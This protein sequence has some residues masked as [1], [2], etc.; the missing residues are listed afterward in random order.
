MGRLIVANVKMM[1]RDRQ[2]LF[3]A[4]IFPLIFVV[5]F[6]LFDVG[7][8]DPVDISIIDLAQSP[9]SK[10]I[11]AQIS[12]IELLDISREFTT[13]EEA[14]KAVED[15]DLEYALIIP[16]EVAEI[17][18]SQGLS[19]PV[20]L[21]L[22]FNQANFQINQLIFGVIG[23]FTDQVNLGLAQAPQRISLSPQ[24]VQDKAVEYFDELVIGLV[25]MAIMFNSIVVIGV[26]ISGYRQ[27]RI[28]RRILVT[29]LPLRNYFAA[30]VLTHLALALVQ[31]S[32]ILA[33][34]IFVFGAEIHGNL[35]W[36]FVIAA[37]ASIVFLNIGFAIGGRA[38]SPAAASGVANVIAMPMMFFSGTFF[39]TSSLPSFLPDLVK[40]LP[41]TPTIDALR[42]VAIDGEALWSTWP[43]LA[44]LAGWIA[45]SGALASR[46]F[47]FN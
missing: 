7:D 46:V 25:G 45:V 35:L 2:T 26:K 37:F 24:A 11:Q 8:P 17:D 13:A 15:G 38:S 22:Y 36:V 47:R 30:E 9:L 32:I 23:Q 41:L 6:G 12:E 44:M 28:L 27:Q 19:P 3:W 21:T 20:P 33:V 42:A 31:T 16:Q 34:G 5:V 10:A 39:P 40:V 29:P 43:E 18:Q 1:V 14:R 4:L